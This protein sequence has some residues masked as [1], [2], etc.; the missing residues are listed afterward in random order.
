[1]KSRYYQK[2]DIFLI[3]YRNIIG[4]SP[5]LFKVT[6]THDIYIHTIFLGFEGKL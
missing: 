6:L 3:S 5:I 2:L 4:L 1:M